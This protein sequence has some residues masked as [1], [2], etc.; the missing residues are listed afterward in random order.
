MQ[1]SQQPRLPNNL[2]KDLSSSSQCPPLLFHLTLCT[3][4][5]TVQ[6]PEQDTMCR[7]LLIA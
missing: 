6:G 5:V 4:F 7:A 2:P 1:H 3:R